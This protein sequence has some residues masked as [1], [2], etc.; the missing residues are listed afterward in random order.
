VTVPI[1]P[2][3]PAEARLFGDA[4]ACDLE[5]AAVFQTGTPSPAALQGAIA[6]LRAVATI[7]DTGVQAGDERLEA[8]QPLQRVEAKLDLMLGLLGRLV[9]RD[10]P[11]MPLIPVRWSYRGM[12]LDLPSATDV[13]PD[14]VG[15]LSL[16][17]APWL[18]VGI[19]L[20]TRVLAS[21][22]A[23][24]RHCLWLAFDSMPDAL[25]DAMERHLFR[26]HRRQ[27]A[28]QRGA[29]P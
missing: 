14:T 1:D 26:L 28:A 17:P 8:N 21:A 25:S 12:R 19:A 10:E 13:A 4:L 2:A 3:H 24:G 16:R 11:R 15:M 22:E 27:V 6:T 9:E 23:G 7:E 20:P 5:V 29:T 18:A